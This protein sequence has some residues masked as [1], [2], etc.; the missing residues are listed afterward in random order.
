[1]YREMKIFG[2]TMDTLAQR[3]VIILKD[4]QGGNTVPIWMSTTEAVA[5]AAS[6]IGRDA[7]EQGG[8][9][10][11]LGV[12]LE[13]LELKISMV[14]IDGLTNGLFSASVRV[15]GKRREIRLDV[16]PAEAI[17]AALTRNLPVMVAESVLE[18]A[19][20]QAMSNENI[21]R[22]HDARRFADFLEKL[23]PADLGK[24]PM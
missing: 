1:M 16:R 24:Y 15:V 12:L 13:N 8:R 7:A 3:P 9:R 20:S 2:F 10:D 19:S 4:M 6:L 23:D 5:I 11:L 17:S 22:E 18:Q 21:S 14:A